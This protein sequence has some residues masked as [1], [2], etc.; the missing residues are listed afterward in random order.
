MARSLEQ[1]GWTYGIDDIKEK[2][3]QYGRTQHGGIH[4]AYY[5]TINQFETPDA[6]E[7]FVDVLIASVKKDLSNSRKLLRKMTMAYKFSEGDELREMNFVQFVFNLIMWG[8]YIYARI[9]VGEKDIFN[10]EIFNNTKYNEYYN[11]FSDNYRNLFTMAEM[12]EL[13]FNVQVN[14]NKLVVAIGPLF[15]HSI[16]IYDMVRLAKEHKELNDIFNTEIDLDNFQV[17]EAEEFLT[18]QTERMFQILM[19]LGNKHNPL[20]AFI[21]AGTGVNKHQVRESYVH[22]GF[23]PDLEGDTIPITTNSN[24]MTEGLK[25]PESVFVDSKGKLCPF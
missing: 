13:F 23:K 8:P 16:S 11:K 25:T 2:I 18:S 10:P 9:P 1:I 6:Y 7:S 24:L 5:P 22:A 15:G 14:M 12:S 17:K 19:G 20:K 4:V 21:R 3:R